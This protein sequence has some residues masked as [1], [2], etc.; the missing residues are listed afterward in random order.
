MVILL[1]FKSKFRPE[2]LLDGNKPLLTEKVSRVLHHSPTLLFQ[3]N[4]YAKEL[5]AKEKLDLFKCLFAWFFYSTQFL[6]TSLLSVWLLKITVATITQH[7]VTVNML[8]QG[9]VCAML[10]SS[11]VASQEHMYCEVEAKPSGCH[12]ETICCSYKNVSPWNNNSVF[13]VWR[14]LM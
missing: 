2:R 6:S 13:Y 5:D 3:L 11:F 1:P 9:L 4:T 7:F 10:L 12:N 14:K 8:F